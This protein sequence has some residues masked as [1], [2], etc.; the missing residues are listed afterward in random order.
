MVVDRR[1]GVSVYYRL[2]EEDQ[3][4]Q[5]TGLWQMFQSH[6]DD[7]LIDADA[8]HLVSVLAQRSKSKNWVDSVAGD[9]ERHYS[10]GRTWE[11]TAYALRG[12]LSLGRTLDIASGDGAMAQLLASQATSLDCVDL[13]EKVVEAG[14]ERAK[15]LSNVEFHVADMHAL[16]FD[17]DAFD[18]VLMLHALTYS[19]NPQK[20]IQESARVLAPHGRLVLAT[21][22]K[23][24]H[25]E[26]VKAYGHVQTGFLPKT[27]TTWCTQAGLEVHFCETTSIE[28]KSPH[29]RI[30]TLLATAPSS[31]PKDC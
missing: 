28:K 30:I 27:L 12:L 25:S 24:E 10:P 16:P 31:Q 15:H 7:A 20:A 3:E 21:L 4:P 1:S 8:Q 13:S 29:F 19:A 2:A 26:Q 5:V 9:M 22:Q 6:L 23:H 14:K 18:T 11:A 17:N